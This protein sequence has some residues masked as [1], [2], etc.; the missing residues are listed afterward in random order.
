LDGNDK[1][2]VNNSTFPHEP[3]PTP[4]HSGKTGIDMIELVKQGKQ[5]EAPDFFPPKRRIN[6]E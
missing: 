5:K 6:Y 1:V 2:K 4:H 3:P